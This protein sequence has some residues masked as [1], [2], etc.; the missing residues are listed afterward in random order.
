MG[1][2]TFS[3]GETYTTREFRE[4]IDAI[5]N[6]RRSIVSIE[7]INRLIALVPT[8][9][10]RR[11]LANHRKEIGDY[12]HGAINDI[13]LQKWYDPPLIRKEKAIADKG[14]AI[15]DEIIPAIVP[16]VTIVKM[17]SP[18]EEQRQRSEGPDL[19]WVKR[20][21]NK[22]VP[23]SDDIPSEEELPIFNLDEFRYRLGKSHGEGPAKT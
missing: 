22:I 14:R 17:P 5:C 18:E 15:M 12:F 4:K 6:W 20:L 3:T 23:P 21:L 11:I 19:P 13:L 10:D 9:G 16:E 1:T 8:K 7:T 2:Y